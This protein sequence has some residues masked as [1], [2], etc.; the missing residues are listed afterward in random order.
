MPFDM[1]FD[2]TKLLKVP[3]FT[4][5]FDYKAIIQQWRDLL[6]H[7]KPQGGYEPPD[8]KGMV[9]ATQLYYDLALCRNV[10]PGEEL[11]MSEDR[12]ETLLKLGVIECI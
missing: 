5:H 10:E 6:G 4:Y 2:V 8:D 1:D 9:R 11:S 7:T 12:I 3:K